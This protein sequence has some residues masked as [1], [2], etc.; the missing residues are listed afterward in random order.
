MDDIFSDACVTGKPMSQ[1]GVD[2]RTEATGLG[3][4][5]ATRYF[6]NNAAVCKRH[7]IKPGI[8]G[9]TVIVQGFGNVGFYAAKYF[10]V[11]T[12]ARP[13]ATCPMLAVHSHILSIV[14]TAT[15]RNVHGE[16]SSPL[17]E[18]PSAG[19]SD[20]FLSCPHRQP[21]REVEMFAALL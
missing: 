15:V 10:Q 17:F 20:C 18:A 7:N 13:H 9:K 4:A 11:R 21:V 1:G 19:L 16:P 12:L 14:S 8:Q 2:G 3:A 6:L 5:Y